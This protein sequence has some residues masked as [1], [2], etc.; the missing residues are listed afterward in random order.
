MASL[1][2]LRCAAGYNLRWLLRAIAR[3]GIGTV[4]LRLL[5]AVL[6]QPSGMVAAHGTHGR[7][8]TTRESNWLASGVVKKPIFGPAAW[9]A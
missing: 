7:A 5:Q 1:R 9:G 4:F 8:L 6:L 3:L 2:P